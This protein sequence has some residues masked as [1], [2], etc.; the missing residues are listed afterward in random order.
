MKWWE[1]YLEHETIRETVGYDA[2]AKVELE[3]LQ[4][5]MEFLKIVHNYIK[6]T[7]IEKLT[8]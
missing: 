7:E 4:P 8:A 1:R 6:M 2:I 3:D 5:V